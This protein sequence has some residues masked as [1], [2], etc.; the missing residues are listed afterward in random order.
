[1]ASRSVAK[2]AWM[3]L[4][5]LIALHPALSQD[6]EEGCAHVVDATASLSADGI[7][8]TIAAT[9]SS[10]ETGWD[11]YA[12]EWKVESEGI[13][14]GTRTLAHPHVTEQ[15]FTRSLSG[16]EIPDDVSV[17]T[18]SAR[19]SVLG[20]CGDS[21]ELRIRGDFDNEENTA[22]DPTATPTAIGTNDGGASISGW[23]E[24]ETF[25]PSNFSTYDPSYSM[26]TMY[27]S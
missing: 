26:Q 14:L 17:V 2:L 22:S 3:L 13:V 24:R 8:W 6:A 25:V 27:P 16:I 11:K 5:L 20:Y 1:M 15:P 9:V 10:T 21:F 12:D 7:T 18:V 23:D 4:A 19:D